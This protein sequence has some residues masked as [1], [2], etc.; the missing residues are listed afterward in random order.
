M[1]SFVK[2]AFMIACVF[3]LNVSNAKEIICYKLTESSNPAIKAGAIQFVSFIGDQCY[4]SNKDGVSVKNGTMQ[5]NSY[6]SKRNAIVYMGG[7]FCGTGA[8]FEFNSDKSI[9]TVT[10]KNKKTY[11]FRKIAR[12]KGVVSSSLIRKH[13]D[14]NIYE[15][16]SWNANTIP[17]N[18]YHPTPEQNQRGGRTTNQRGSVSQHRCAY[19]NG[20]G[21]ITKNDNAPSNFGIDK[22]KKQC[23]TCGE[24]YNPNVFN[25]Y[26]VRCGHCGGSGVSR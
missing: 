12:P 1:T 10:A 9:L 18:S 25:H 21:K 22:P 19:C 7:C 8:K 26:H 11:K 13:V 6:Q 15:D 5:K 4:E 20:T 16:N 2:Y 14:A 23:A 24:W 17:V 3:F